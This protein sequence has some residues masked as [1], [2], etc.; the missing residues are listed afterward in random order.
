MGVLEAPMVSYP[1][2]LLE[3]FELPRGHFAAQVGLKS[4]SLKSI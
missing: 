4:I 3:L 2:S 1:Y